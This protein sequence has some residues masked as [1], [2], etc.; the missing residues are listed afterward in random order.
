MKYVF[1]INP[2]AGDGKFVDN[3]EKQIKDCFTK[4]TDDFEIYETINKGDGKKRV[5]EL[6]ETKKD[7]TFVSCGGDGTIHEIINGMA[8]Y[9]NATLAI[10]PLGSG[11]DFVRNFDNFQAFLDIEA[12]ISGHTEKIDLLKVNDEY[13]IT[14]GNVGYDADVAFNM[15]KFKSVPLLTGRGRYNVSL[16]YSLIHKLGK[17]LV[18][19]FDDGTVMSHNL[20]LGVVANGQTYGSGYMCAPYATIDD[21][22]LDVC[23]MKKMSRFKIL[24]MINSYKNGNH[25]E[26]P[27][28]VDYAIYKKCKS[29]RLT[30]ENDIH[31]CV[32]GE[33]MGGKDFYFQCMEKKLN[34]LIPKGAKI[35][36]GRK[37]TNN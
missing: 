20:L 4:T 24:Q 36:E 37:K 29:V 21:G 23:L 26:D 35:I 19:E 34:F 6:C 5:I 18:Y 28:L 32:D 12:I 9:K 2:I 31:L 1:I 30:S 3:L 15:T 33:L 25:I 27:N 10:M 11:N 17:E 14:V 7:I 13:V 16:I 8:G 22:I